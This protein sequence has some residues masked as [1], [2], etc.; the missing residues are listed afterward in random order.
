MSMLTGIVNFYLG[1]RLLTNNNLLKSKVASVAFSNYLISIMINWTYNIYTIS[2]W[3]FFVFPLWG[4]YIYIIMIYFVV[5]DDIILLNYLWKAMYP[6]KQ[7]YRRV[8]REIRKT[9]LM[10]KVYTKQWKLVM[11]ELRKTNKNAKN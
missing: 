2:S 11:K 5:K 1:F 10:T 6:F 9:V 4:L 7:Q 8:L 3:I